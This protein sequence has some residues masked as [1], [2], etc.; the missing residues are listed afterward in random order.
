MLRLAGNGLFL[1]GGHG[2]DAFEGQLG[3]EVGV[4]LVVV[5]GEEFLQGPA[6]DFEEASSGPAPT[7]CRRREVQTLLDSMSSLSR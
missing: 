4:E 6:A 5:G 2:P 3:F 1:L 7:A